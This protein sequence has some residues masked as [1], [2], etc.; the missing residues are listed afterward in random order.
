MKIKEIIL[1]AEKN[2]F[3]EIDFDLHTEKLKPVFTSEECATNNE[4]SCMLDSGAGIP[5]WCTGKNTL[6]DAF[7]TAVLKSD[8]KGLLG[9]FGYIPFITEVFYIPKISICN[10]KD[11]ILFKDF[12]LPVID[13]KSFGTD[14]I[15]P[16][17]I[18]KN[19]NILI[20]QFEF[21]ENQK[22]II[23]TILSK[24]LQVTVY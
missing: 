5:V 20:S 2:H 22:E 14:L 23:D 4:F 18:F 6:I 1:E 16:S 10:G 19:S 17:S 8:L 11:S 13:K 12:Y 15:I 24:V 3:N 21:K 9:G 7:P